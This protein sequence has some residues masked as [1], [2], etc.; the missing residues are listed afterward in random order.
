M[1][2][3]DDDDLAA[4][5]TLA[6]RKPPAI[7]L[8]AWERFA[9]VRSFEVATYPNAVLLRLMTEGGDVA[10][11]KLNPVIAR[12]L[13]RALVAAGQQGRWL[14]E[15]LNVVAPDLDMLD[16]NAEERGHE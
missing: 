4:W 16:G 14:D 9:S 2:A 5:R 3:F 8:D 15:A 10:D 12:S 11:L 13:F 7:P 1:K 6:G